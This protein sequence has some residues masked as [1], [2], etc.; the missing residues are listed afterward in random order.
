MYQS[1]L[2]GR[3]RRYATAE[4]T[5]VATAMPNMAIIGVQ[6]NVTVADK[7]TI[8]LWAGATATGTALTGIVTFTT[9]MALGAPRYLSI[10]A[11]A[12][13]G[14]CINITGAPDVTLYWNPV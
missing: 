6:C 11:Y 3:S 12:A 13:G 4:A 5:V 1:N 9:G 2:T 14:A 7:T 8:Q 10:P